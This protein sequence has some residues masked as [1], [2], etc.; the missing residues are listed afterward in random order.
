VDE[1]ETEL[2]EL[3]TALVE[4]EATPYQSPNIIKKRELETF[5]ILNAA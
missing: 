3:K 2:F 5:T 1:V 4:T